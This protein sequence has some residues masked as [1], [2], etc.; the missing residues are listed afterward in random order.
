MARSDFRFSFPKRVRMA[1]VDAAGIVFNARHLDY[2]NI[3]VTEYL[4]AV[5]GAASPAAPILFARSALDYRAPCRFD[6][7]LALC[8]RCDRIGRTSLTL[9][10]EIHGPAG[11]DARCIGETVIVH[12]PD[13][14]PAPV[15][16]T[17]IER[18]EG[19]EGRS[20]RA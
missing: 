19:Y 13:M 2:M 7:L 16:E 6:E 18:L 14:R 3:A 15:P 20:L 11:E 10:W 8:L 4:R 9:A 17:W 12:A 5:R 1:E